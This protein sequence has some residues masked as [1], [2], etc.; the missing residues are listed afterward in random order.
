MDFIIFRESYWQMVDLTC[1]LASLSTAFTLSLVHFKPSLRFDL[2][3]KSVARNRVVV[4]TFMFHSLTILLHARVFLMCIINRIFYCFFKFTTV[5]RRNQADSTLLC[6]S[7]SSLQPI[8]TTPRRWIFSSENHIFLSK[9]TIVCYANTELAN[10]Q[11]ENIDKIL[12][13]EIIC[14]WMT[15]LFFDWVSLIYRHLNP[16]WN[17]LF[18]FLDSSYC[19]K[20]N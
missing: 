1:H 3:F 18:D 14:D 16:F 11:I 6:Q 13:R 17:V 19:A 5:E 20:K 4:R 15:L 7:S 10:M 8:N 12:K 9:S 2:V